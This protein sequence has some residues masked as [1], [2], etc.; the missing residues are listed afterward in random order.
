MNIFQNEININ[1]D[2]LYFFQNELAVSE[3]I[4]NIVETLNSYFKKVVS[5]FNIDYRKIQLIDVYDKPVLFL[6]FF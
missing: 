2:N 5:V 4:Q 6:C 1:I 3:F